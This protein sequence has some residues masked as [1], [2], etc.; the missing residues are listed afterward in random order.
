MLS[1]V[2]AANPAAYEQVKGIV[3]AATGQP[4]EA[5]GDGHLLQW[6]VT[7]GPALFAFITQI[8]NMFPKQPVTPPATPPAP[9]T[10]VG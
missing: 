8:I 1:Q 9:V 4:V 6:L 10:P 2:K 7:N 5:I 3:A